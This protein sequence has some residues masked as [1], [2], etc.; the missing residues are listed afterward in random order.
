[1]IFGKYINRY[2]LKNAPVLLLGL[3]ALLTVD[4]IQLLIPRLYR[5]VINGVN[6]GQVVVDGQT[7]AFGKEVLFQHICLPMIYIIILM[8]LGRFLW[9]VCFFGSAVRVTA[10]LRERMFDHSRQLSQQYY[11]VNKVGNLMS[12]YTN[13]LDTIQE[14]FGDG[15]LM[16]FDALT[17]GLLALYKM[18]NMDHQLTLLALIPALLMLAIGTV[19][20]KTMTKTWEKRQ[21]AFSDLSDF[22]Q[23]NFSGIAVIKAFVK[24][25]KELIAFRKLNKENEKIN[26]EYTRISVLLE[27]MVTLFVESVICVILGFGG[28]LVYVGQFNAGQLVE[29]IGYF[30]AIVWPIMAVAMLIEKSSRGKASLNRITELLDAPIDVADRPGV[31]DLANV[32]GGVEFRDLTFRY[33]D[34]EFDVLKNISFTI[35]PGERVGIVG[36]TGAG[37]TALVD[38]LLRTYNVPDGTLF[39]DG[40]DVNTVSIHSVRN[41]CAY[42]PQDNFLFSDTIAH[43]IGFGVDDATRE[44]ID[45]AAALADVRDNIVDFKDGYETV[46]GER[47][48]TVSG[49]QKQRISIA[50]ALL[51]N[52]PILILDDSVSAV[53]TRTEKIILDNLKASRAG[54]TTLLIAH[55]ISAVEGLDKIIFLE[56]GRVEAVGPHDSLYASCPE[57]RRMV[58]LQRLEDEVGGDSNG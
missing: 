48:V 9:R 41:A 26:V 4:Y 6:L 5:L 38:L 11:Q 24:E 53:D 28:Y 50:R 12:L 16:F 35:Q 31:P 30:E 3:A 42:V 25:L 8:V 14:C 2:Y 44:D 39:V 20:G 7:V 43:N 58:D 45:R 34:G 47:G 13:D 57:Y 55:R 37:K 21:Q 49:G 19:M 32:Q 1:M 17:L 36:K 10:D 56:D 54:K 18:W 22:A 33:P 29:Y 27:I 15:V 40:K 52:A 23:E 51:K 46:L